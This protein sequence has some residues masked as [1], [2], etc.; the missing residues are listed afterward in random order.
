M[1][2]QVSVVLAWMTALAIAT[3][4]VRR[5]TDLLRFSM[6]QRGDVAAGL[7]LGAPMPRELAARGERRIVVFL[8]SDCPP[9][10]AFAADLGQLADR[11]QLTV[12][13]SGEAETALEMAR[14]VPDEARLLFGKSADEA[15]SAARVTYQPFAIAVADGIVVGKAYPTSVGS[16][17]QLFDEDYVG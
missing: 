16:L 2:I 3:V 10:H 9:C 15:A 11:G 17:E 8:D 12:A 6:L 1:W 5:E 14:T 4:A 7:P 13:I